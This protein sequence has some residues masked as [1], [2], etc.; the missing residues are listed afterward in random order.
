MFYR[1]CFQLCCT[2]RH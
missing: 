2:V 1:H